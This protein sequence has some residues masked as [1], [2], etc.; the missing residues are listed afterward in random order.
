M[1]CRTRK[2]VLL[3]VALV[4][5]CLPL[6]ETGLA[7]TLPLPEAAAPHLSDQIHTQC[8]ECL[9][10][11]FFPSGTADIGFGKRFFPNLFVG[12]PGRGMLISYIMSGESYVAHLR[13]DDLETARAALRKAFSAAR[14]FLIERP[15]YRVHMADP[16]KSVAVIL[17]PALHAC[18][19]GSGR[20]LCCCCT[21]CQ[22]ECCEKRLGST[23]VTVRWTHPLKSD[24]TITYTYYPHPGTSK[25]YTVTADGTRKD[26]RW[27]LDSAGPGFLK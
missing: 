9:D 20:P 5:T 24:Q 10:R 11:G 7:G 14:L 8:P 26:L 22:T 17:T 18:L 12:N 13:Q 15:H 2:G 27:V 16:P 21:D 25:V 3:V 6:W 1:D 23:A 4:V 19:H